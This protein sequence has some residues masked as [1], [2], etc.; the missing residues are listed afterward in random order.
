M[1]TDPLLEHSKVESNDNSDSEYED[2]HN[3]APATQSEINNNVQ[4]QREKQ[5]RSICRAEQ[6]STNTMT[7]LINS[8]QETDMVE[9]MK[10]V[11][12]YMLRSLALVHAND[13]VL[14]VKLKDTTQTLASS[15][16]LS[17]ANTFTNIS[18]N[19]NTN[20]RSL[21]VDGSKGENFA[22]R[23][24][25]MIPM[26]LLRN[27]LKSG[28]PFLAQLDPEAK[29]AAAKESSKSPVAAT[30]AGNTLTFKY[31]LSIEAN[32][33]YFQFMSNR[34]SNGEQQEL[35]KINVCKKPLAWSQFDYDQI[36]LD[37]LLNKRKASGRSKTRFLNSRALFDRLYQYFDHALKYDFPTRQAAM[38]A[39][40]LQSTGNMSKTFS[41]MSKATKSTK[42]SQ[43]VDPNVAAV[44]VNG[45]VRTCRLKNNQLII[46]F[47]LENGLVYL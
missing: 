29:V 9:L 42:A 41:S 35:H 1:N 45:L 14:S 13:S 19:S 4:L 10:L 31:M 22:L 26:D 16:N 7:S 21:V 24:D 25:S 27:G 30:L 11:E 36:S 6:Q 34:V 15:T 20:L 28:N 37:V 23:I 47:R 3:Y 44:D 40:A 17:S 46:T 8:L 12:I 33:N 2:E 43:D 18:S 38:Q 39:I 5:Y 32:R